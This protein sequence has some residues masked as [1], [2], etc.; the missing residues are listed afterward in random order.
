MTSTAVER[1]INESRDID[2]S[3]RVRASLDTTICESC[4]TARGGAWIVQCDDCD[5]W[6]HFNC[7]E[8]NREDFGE[9]DPWSCEECRHKKAVNDVNS[10]AN[11]TH[12]MSVKP[13][14]SKLRESTSQGNAS[15]FNEMAANSTAQS[16]LK[17]QR[18]Y[19]EESGLHRERERDGQF[20][21]SMAVKAK[22]N[23]TERRCE[24]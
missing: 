15:G 17:S 6:F 14:N 24:I 12:R 21:S 8:F 7:V 16:Q 23:D 11:Q 4:K 19:V 10:Q 1:L 18:N 20:I 13:I 5:K 9:D 3:I 22:S 2:H